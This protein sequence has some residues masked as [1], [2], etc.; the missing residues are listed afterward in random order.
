MND[1]WYEMNNLGENSVILKKRLEKLRSDY[2]S[3]CVD[4][5]HEMQLLR[6]V[7]EE[8]G[9]LGH[10][11]HHARGY[12]LANIAEKALSSGENR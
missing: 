2:F 6:N 4:S 11:T 3:M 12:T 9:R 8:I 10:S 7:L 1:L 5:N